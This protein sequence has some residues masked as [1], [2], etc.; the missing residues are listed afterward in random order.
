[1]AHSTELKLEDIIFALSPF[2]EEQAEGSKERK[3][4]SIAQAAL[5][6]I[7]E[8]ENE[9]D[10]A[11]YY[12]TFTRMELTQDVAHEFATREEADRWLTT[13]KAVHKESVKISGK[14][15]MTVQVSGKWYFMVS[16]LP[17]ELRTAEWTGEPES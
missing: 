5:M 13:G 12:E 16:P 15:F 7:R 4:L 3:V 9:E 11:R 8:Q 6:Y 17:E 14:G 1:M 10:F 2:I